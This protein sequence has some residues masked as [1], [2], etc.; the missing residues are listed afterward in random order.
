[1]NEDASKAK[2]KKERND[3]VKGLS[4]PPEQAVVP[5]TDSS[6]ESNSTTP[7][8]IPTV[9]P[10]IV[11]S[12][13]NVLEMSGDTPKSAGPDINL[14]DALTAASKSALAIDRETNQLVFDTDPAPSSITYSP[15][16]LFKAETTHLKLSSMPRLFDLV[17]VAQY[18]SDPSAR[19]VYAIDK[20]DLPP[21][22]PTSADLFHNQA[23]VL[24]LFS[25]VGYPSFRRIFDVQGPIVH[26]I[27]AFLTE[28]VFTDLTQLPHDSGYRGGPPHVNYFGDFKY[29]G[30]PIGSI[31]PSNARINVS[32]LFSLLIAGSLRFFSDSLKIIPFNYSKAT[33]T[34]IGAPIGDHMFDE[35]DTHPVFAVPHCRL[36]W[37]PA[38]FAR[39][40][41]G[42]VVR[43]EEFDPVTV[44]QK[45]QHF[46]AW[47]TT[48][49]YTS[50]SLD[51]GFTIFL[52]QHLARQDYINRHLANAPL[53]MRLSVRHDIV[54]GKEIVA[55]STARALTIG[56]ALDFVS[57]QHIQSN[58]RD[59]VELVSGSNLFFLDPL[60]KCV[61]WMAESFKSD[62]SMS[63]LITSVPN[64]TTT[65][66]VDLFVWNHFAHQVTVTFTHSTLTTYFQGIKGIIDM[67]YTFVNF[68]FLCQA[69]AHT[70]FPLFWA[71]V[72]SVLPTDYDTFTAVH[73]FVWSVD[74]ARLGN[75]RYQATNLRTIASRE[76]AEV[77]IPSFHVPHLANPRGV[78]QAFIAIRAFF[79]NFTADA[80]VLD[81]KNGAYPFTST[82]FAAHRPYNVDLQQPEANHPMLVYFGQIATIFQLI[83]ASSPRRSKLIM[84]SQNVNMHALGGL[85]RSLQDSIPSCLWAIG[86]SSDNLMQSAFYKHSS[87][88]AINFALAPRRIGLGSI[89]VQ[90]AN[91]GQVTAAG[92]AQ[93]FPISVNPYVG[94]SIFAA[95]N[96]KVFPRGTNWG[97]VALSSDTSRLNFAAI[98]TNAYEVA[99]LR[100]EEKGQAGRRTMNGLIYLNFLR[101][102][103]IG[104]GAGGFIPPAQLRTLCKAQPWINILT[105]IDRVCGSELLHLL[106][107]DN[108][109]YHSDVRFDNMCLA[110]Y[111]RNPTA[112]FVAPANTIF[113]EA[114]LP[115]AVA[116]EAPDTFSNARLAMNLFFRTESPVTTTQTGLDLLT[117]SV[118]SYRI[119]PLTAAE[120]GVRVDV[121]YEFGVT[122]SVEQDLQGDRKFIELGGERIFDFR[123]PRLSG[124]RL[125][126]P[127]NIYINEDDV[128]FLLRLVTEGSLMVRLPHV[129]YFV[130][131]TYT[132]KPQES[133]SVAD[134]RDTAIRV[135]ALAPA[136]M[137]TI[138]F[139]DSSLALKDN[140]YNTRTTALYQV[141]FPI[142]APHSPVVARSLVG[143]AP[144]PTFE[145]ANADVW[146]AG[147]RLANG[148]LNTVGGQRKVT[149]RQANYNNP[150]RVLTE[151]F[152]V[153]SSY[154]VDSSP[155]VV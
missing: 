57:P 129:K 68:P 130:Q 109:T 106:K 74:E 134:L 8:T 126:I 6:V 125:V 148:Q 136:E 127:E 137:P 58:L 152:V 18:N 79:L 149:Q 111:P 13:P 19:Y 38:E 60:D 107:P 117:L 124:F 24:S 115:A 9:D 81:R 82:N 56:A 14:I 92:Y 146:C 154:F 26:T 50:E 4:L 132:S 33:T 37:F 41:G 112:P 53:G 118:R 80:V 145:M 3:D 133:T 49:A 85:L 113:H 66:Y 95:L 90:G 71:H 89:A 70:F 72:K 141:A 12:G 97:T 99:Y 7:K 114:L 88:E 110:L 151:D 11:G 84:T 119:T 140:V 45:K 54:T 36:R 75:N 15:T 123:D 98:N 10:K 138:P 93:L 29:I 39:V 104:N 21:A 20:K 128:D 44:H 59:A 43:L 64:I 120:I 55:G 131:S 22:F 101:D 5:P 28:Q 30:H 69:G 103:I 65:G 47:M 73:G 77:H 52:N 42:A 63:A 48:D 32:R 139:T 86:F 17:S 76:E 150:L 27:D 122:I 147:Q 40:T 121:D 23:F 108:S 31:L 35:C 51:H 34:A 67:L 1:M 87:H 2:F 61:Q 155:V 135:L 62:P 144:L 105:D 96:T 25:P 142:N 102:Y 78:S 153:H 83:I 116:A 100:A 94:F 46:R 16:P 91:V 143:S